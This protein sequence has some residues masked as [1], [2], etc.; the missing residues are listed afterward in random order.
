MRLS[1]LFI[2]MAVLLLSQT[3]R[4][5]LSNSLLWKV[6]G[7]G[8]KEASYVYGTIH[9]MCPEELLIDNETKSAFST[10]DQLVLELDMDDPNFVSSVQQA[11][12]NPDMKNI[13]EGLNE[14][15]LKILN[16][17]FSTNYGADLS[18]FGIIKPFALLSMMTVK[19]LDCPQPASYEQRFIQMATEKGVETK[20]LETIEDQVGIFDKVP[21]EEQI[22]W[23]VNIAKNPEEFK[24]DL[25]LLLEAYHS[26]DLEIIYSSISNY[27]E[28]EFISEDLL[29]KRNKNWVDP[30][31][32][33]AKDKSTFFAI[34]AA[35]LG[36]ENG[37]IQL[38]RSEGFSVEAVQ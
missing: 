5:Q 18:R 30:M 31:I 28:Y 12:M 38:L 26:R 9:I 25:A 1:Q 20:G 14:E 6:S 3:V 35:H 21:L 19:G 24:G 13:S 29:D 37:V 15:D 7:N 27:P 17:Y 11:S 4:G 33:M 36:G 23:L 8:L 32:E 34:G 2:A 22:S 16:E 10:T